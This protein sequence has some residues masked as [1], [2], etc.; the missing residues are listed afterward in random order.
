MVAYLL[1]QLIRAFDACLQAHKSDDR[2]SLDLMRTPHHSS[3][4][5]CLVRD[6]CTFNLGSAESVARDI[7]HIIE[8][9][10]DGEIPLLVTDGT[11]TSGIHTGVV[12]PV[13]ILIAFFIT[14]NRTQHT[15]PWLADD[16]PATF[17]RLTL[18]A[19][20]IKN[21]GIN[22]KERHGGSTRPDR[23]A[24]RHRRNHD[25]TGLGLPPGVNDRA[26]AAADLIVIPHPCLRVDRFTDGS[27]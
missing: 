22:A 20:F 12:T 4:S 16:Q 6:K 18:L 17:V 9:S 13:S 10:D 24:T 2:L 26:A 27:E 25:G 23:R 3:L 7:E 15:W 8:P 1:E 14:V 21:G 11:V 19:F 5:H